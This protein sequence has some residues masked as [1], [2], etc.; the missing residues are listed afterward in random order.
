LIGAAG[1]ASAEIVV[2]VPRDVATIQQA[3]ETVPDGAVIEIAPGTYSAPSGGWHINNPAR[4]FTMR[5]ES[6]T[7]ILDGGGTQP[8][9][10]YLVDNASLQG[11]VVFVDLVI[12]NG[13]SQTDG[14]VGGVSL[15]E[16]DATFR[17]CTFS[18]NNGD[19]PTTGGGGVGVFDGSSAVFDDCL[20]TGNRA[21]NGGAALRIGGDSQ[22]WIYRS[23]VLNNRSNFPGHRPTATAGGID[24]NNA[25]L[26]VANT[27]FE[28]NESGFAGGAIYTIGEWQSP[29][30]QA[31][32]VI[33]VANCTFEGN[34]AKPDPGVSSPSPTEGG[35]IHVEDQAH[36]LVVNS[37][38]LYN[39]ADLGGGLSLYRGVATV[40]DSVFIGNRAV[41]IGSSTG[42]GG[43]IKV[44]SND[45]PEDGTTNYPSS[46][47]TVRDSYFQGRSGAVT[48]VGQAA[49]GIFVSGDVRRTYGLSGS[50]IIGT[51]AT[52]RAPLIIRRTIFADCDVEPGD[53]QS[54]GIGGGMSLSH[55]DGDMSDSLIMGSDALGD[56]SNAGAMRVI[57]ESDFTANDTTFAQNSA[58]RFGGAI[59]A[60]GTDFTLDGCQLFENEI[61]PGVSE[62][63][64]ESYGAAIFAA[65][66]VNAFPGFDL[67]IS[68]VLALSTL[69]LNTGIPIFDDDR[70][71][72][73]INGMRYNGNT[74]H[75]TTFSDRIYRHSMV[76]SKTVSELNSLV[77]VHSGIDK[78]ANN[79]W[80]S[81]A[82]VLGVLRAAPSKILPT[83]AAGDPGSSTEAYLGY[84][85]SGGSAILDGSTVNGGIGFETAAVG[86][87]TLNVSGQDFVAI[88]GNGA[89]PVATLTADPQSIS[90]GG[91]TTLS[92]STTSGTYI[93][94]YLDHGIGDLGT[95]SGSIVVAPTATTT[96]TLMVVTEEGGIVAT[97]TVFVDELEGLIFADGFES[98]D[99]TEWDLT[100]P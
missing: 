60:A 48:T 50:P 78:G 92:W 85:W 33:V 98:G 83:V 57:H 47:L 99:T 35:A 7:V 56:S 61:S 40:E 52:N 43:A 41:D 44:T 96:Y 89:T 32:S 87:H 29:W 91:S 39:D 66:I 58:N 88:I 6:G 20:W 93:G 97:T 86:S 2:K 64:S 51:P 100:A 16:A 69:S 72:S 90:G 42:F 62:A 76:G 75:N 22:V 25:T 46:E 71:P 1:W 34:K 9:L 21:A 94:A 45:G 80:S 26:W 84:A 13:R 81:S 14:T 53:A 36:L 4:T 28:G 67:P 30:Q 24:V 10:R 79:Q 5:A 49:G 54:K 23:R 73:P 59:Y 27:R 37:R 15:Y 65:P 70:N 74:F 17:G 95:A 3:I 55:V 31:R 68:G 18:N 38:F 19:S 77:L 12:A 63:E 11:S 8:V 82:P